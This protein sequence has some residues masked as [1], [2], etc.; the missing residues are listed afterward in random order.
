[1]H[2]QQEHD[3]KQ[4]DMEREERQRLRMMNDMNRPPSPPT[5]P[6]YSDGEAHTLIEDLKAE[7]ANFNRA[8]EILETWL[9]RGDCNKRNASMFFTMIQSANV[10][11]K[12]LISEKN[13]FE[14]EMQRLKDQWKGKLLLVDT[15]FDQIES[16][17]TNASHQKV[18]DHFT[19]AQRKNIQSWKG[20]LAEAKVVAEVTAKKVEDA[21]EDEEDEKP[22]AKRAKKSSAEAKAAKAKMEIDNEKLKEESENWAS[23]AN[24][25]RN[26]VGSIKADMTAEIEEKN[27]QIKILQ[28]T[29][30]G[31]QKQLI[32]M[33]KKKAE[34]AAGPPKPKVLIPLKEAESRS[35]AVIST[36]LQPHPYGVS[37]DYIWT[38]ILKIDST[39]TKEQVCSVLETY[40]D[41]FACEENSEKQKTWKFV[42]FDKKY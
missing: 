31:M 32:E 28:Q 14:T 24:A 4:R 7:G 16:V 34:E 25:Y 35:L 5:I 30:Q 11:V 13:D 17:F 41:C 6:F 21:D 1:M 37:A 29:L 36:F 20:Q 40:K 42:A 26:E 27:N 38:H 18:W 2:D 9:S 22:A 10:P 33:Q 19:K 23:Q 15:Q 3:Q 8:V 39:I 12:K